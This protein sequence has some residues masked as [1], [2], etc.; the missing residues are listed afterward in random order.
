VINESDYSDQSELMSLDAQ[1]NHYDMAIA[2]AQARR[3]H[4]IIVNDGID[5]EIMS[6]ESLK[7]MLVARKMQLESSY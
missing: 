6:Y 3:S 4:H 5:N 1:I 2:A 7:S